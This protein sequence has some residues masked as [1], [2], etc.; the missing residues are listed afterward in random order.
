MPK[1]IIVKAGREFP[2]EKIG[3]RRVLLLWKGFIS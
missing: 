2:E 1:I 3:R